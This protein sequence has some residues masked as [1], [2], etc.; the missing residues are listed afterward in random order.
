MESDIYGKIRNLEGASSFIP[1]RYQGRYEDIETGLYYN[2]L[3]YYDCENG[4]YIS[5][6][7]LSILGGFNFYSYANDVNSQI[8]PFGL[9]I[10]QCTRS[11]CQSW[12][13][14]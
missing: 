11:K 4:R 10:K 3:K 5:Q 8:D 9:I 6:D 7:P 12:T 14:N 2:R 1:F 13:S